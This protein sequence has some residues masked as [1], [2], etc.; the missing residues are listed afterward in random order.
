MRF[1]TLVSDRIRSRVDQDMRGSG[2][3]SDGRGSA[4]VS[5]RS[6]SS[7]WDT[8]SHSLQ[9][10]DS[11]LPAGSLPLRGLF[12]RALHQALGYSRLAQQ[13][14]ESCQG[15]VLSNTAPWQSREQSINTNGTRSTFDCRHKSFSDKL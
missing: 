11:Q 3:V 14:S 6:F 9:R 7:S 12:G 8:S 10:M 5:A 13:F 4:I 1:S 2:K 15:A